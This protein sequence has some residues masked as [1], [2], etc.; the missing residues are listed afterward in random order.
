MWKLK[1][2]VDHLLKESVE[3][4]SGEPLLLS[5]HQLSPSTG[6][7][8]QAIV[9]VGRPGQQALRL[10]KPRQV[11]T[12][13]NDRAMRDLDGDSPLEMPVARLPT[14]AARKPFQRGPV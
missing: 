4:T 8:I 14:D 12:N 10:G 7:H 13:S 9:L 2:R 5:K 1:D 6:R 3:R 11:Q